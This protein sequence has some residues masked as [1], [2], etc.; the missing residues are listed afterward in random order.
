MKYVPS[1][2]CQHNW[3]HVLSATHEWYNRGRRFIY[4]DGGSM[5][6]RWDLH[7]HTPAS[8]PNEFKFINK[9]EELK[10]NGDIWQ[11]YFDE[12][13]KI[14]DISVIGITDYFT[15]EG[16]MKALE[17]RNNMHLQNFDLILP[18]I[19]FR[20]NTLTKE[21]RRLNMHLI[22]SD[23]I[24]IADI[25]DFLGRVKLTLSDP[26]VQILQ[27]VSCTRNGLMQ[28]GRAYKNDEGLSDAEAYKIGCMQ[29][30]IELHDLLKVLAETPNFKD[31]YLVVGVE[32]SPGGLSEIPYAQSGHLR[33]EI[34]RKCH[35]IES[36]NE[37]TRKFWL[38]KS[39]KISEAEL[40]QRF[41]YLKP[42]IHGSDAHCF[43]R[44]CKP[45]EDKFCWIKAEPS[46]E[47][48]KQITYEPEER[49]IIQSENPEHWK[50]IYTLAFTEIKNSWISNELEIEE[51]NIPLNRNLVAITGG[52]G[53]GKTALLDL[54]ANCFED[55]CNRANVG[56]N[57][58][59]R[60]IEDQKK[61]LKVQIGF[62][63]KD[64]NP[65]SKE[66][67][68][69]AFC[70]DSRITY[71]PQGTIEIL[72]ASRERLNNRIE[73]IIFN[74]KEVVDKGYKQKFDQLR[75]AIVQL[76]KQIDEKNRQICELEEE[77]QQRVMDEIKR[78]KAI[79]EGELKNKEDELGKLT[80]DMED[81]IRQK[82]AELKESEIELQLQNFKLGGL[83]NQLE[84]FEDK[85]QEFLDG[86]N[87]MV[88]ELNDKFSSVF[89][90]VAIPK[91]DFKPQFDA[92][93][94]AQ[95]LIASKIKEVTKQ[96]QEVQEPLSQLSGVQK[97]L[98]DI[99]KDIRVKKAEIESL[100]KQLSELAEKK[101]RKESFEVTRRE[102]YQALLNKYREWKRYY[103]EVI[104]AFSSGKSEILGSVD[105]VSSIHFFKD[106]FIADGLE[107]LDLRS[108]NEKAIRK[109][110]EELATI[111]NG[112][113]H[114][115]STQSLDSFLS[116]I[117]KKK[118]WLKK[119]RTSYDLYKW[120]FG[121]HFTLNTKIFFRDTPM[122]KLSIGQKGM[123]LLKLVLAEGDYPLI[124][125]QPEENLDN[126]YIYEEL[127]GAFREAKKN[128]QVI[129]ATN[130]ANL[131]VNTDAE[132]VIAAK[133]DNNVISY[134][135]GS[136]EN[137]EM[138]DFIIHVLEGGEDAFK[139]RERKYGI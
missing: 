131:V 14:S 98:T 138:R 55:R 87:K 9:Q 51:I 83:Q 66:I 68:N 61:D 48:L 81:D 101:S 41:G 5:W 10:Y 47:G 137:P 75:G 114:E 73:E 132:Q 37:K 89:G 60:R 27:G 92:T 96:I 86:I 88:D 58:F 74:N 76:A 56:G 123:V 69:Q 118:R 110:A 113:T 23:S 78:A 80:E 19:E 120:V 3:F 7:V 12:L 72:S 70:T 135:S 40:I 67:T 130:N 15:I 46:F 11:K 6:R 105:F 22:F 25:N 103:E 31:N 34:Y 119:T 71:L 28:V 104:N 107:L 50:N 115:I 85:L 21:G 133:F 59:I 112:D 106:S 65:F 39:D 2:L 16:Y 26:C 1:V 62:I 125:D 121:N 99:L 134:K 128:R 126:R 122:D 127:V 77:T 82:I 79:K 52:K 124:V 29:A 42:C 108:V 109:H 117:L 20:L 33:T 38:G 30:A 18:N 35:I 43:E 102:Q 93:R 44:L 95:K 129:I 36:S 13:E 57:S 8:S 116:R 84:Q 97:E 4:M 111:I 54:I 24:R 139:K 32:D 45:A 91:L 53:S 136:L 64:A 17:Y 90:I 94:K 63:G 100:G 49:I